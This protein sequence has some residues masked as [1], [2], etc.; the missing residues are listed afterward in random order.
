MSKD[1]FKLNY[2]EV[3]RSSNGVYQIQIGDHIYI[4]SAASKL[5]F[6]VRWN[7]HISDMNNGVHHSIVLQRCFNKYK[8]AEFTILEVCDSA[9]CI[10][11]EQFYINTLKPDMNILPTAGSNLGSKRPSWK[12]KKHSEETKLKIGIAHS[13]PIEQYTKDM[14]FVKEWCSTMSAARD[15][16]IKFTSINNCLTARSKSAGGFVWKYKQIGSNTE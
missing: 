7:R 13:I 15:L 9:D 16:D 12:G 2:A 5:G 1:I 10:A 11:R 3:D 8:E 6:R 4:G 14:A